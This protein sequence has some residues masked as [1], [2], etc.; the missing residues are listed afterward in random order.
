MHRIKLILILSICCYFASF[1]QDHEAI[2]NQ[3]RNRIYT[4]QPDVV[5]YIIDS[6][7]SKL[8]TP[9]AE[10]L[11]ECIMGAIRF[12]SKFGDEKFYKPSNSQFNKSYDQAAHYVIQLDIV[13]VLVDG[14]EIGDY[15][16]R[17][18]YTV[19]AEFSMI[20]LVKGTREFS[21][22]IIFSGNADSVYDQSFADEMSEYYREAILIQLRTTFPHVYEIQELGEVSKNKAKSVVFRNG[23]YVVGGKPK[24]LGVYILD[25]TIK[26]EGID[27]IYTFKRVGSLRDMKKVEGN[28]CYYDVD[29][30]KSEIYELYS[31]GT[32]LYVTNL[33]LGK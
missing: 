24:Y 6:E 29:K 7:N 19:S 28:K 23:N 20:D 21:K 4:N 27:P 3:L 2:K 14:K 31:N 8:P 22:A 1:G 32:E 33:V 5:V 30:G 17:G 15:P 12:S 25:K 11:N 26:V 13:D 9:L 18:E 16:S 10:K